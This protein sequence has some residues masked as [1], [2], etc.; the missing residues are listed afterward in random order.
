MVP[1]WRMRSTAGVFAPVWPWAGGGGLCVGP[2]GRGRPSLAGLGRVHPPIQIVRQ[3]A[4]PV[5]FLPLFGHSSAGTFPLGDP[6]AVRP[7]GIPGLGSAP[8]G[9]RPHGMSSNSSL[10]IFVQCPDPRM[11]DIM[12]N[13]AACPSTARLIHRGRMACEELAGGC[14]W[15]A[16]WHPVIA[17][18]PWV[19]VSCWLPFSSHVHLQGTAICPRAAWMAPTSN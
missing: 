4:A 11:S 13:M 16:P 2:S 6:F 18:Q 5:A 3:T 8:C 10:A 15:G 17:R 1:I 9:P 19:G 7:W 14:G 12:S